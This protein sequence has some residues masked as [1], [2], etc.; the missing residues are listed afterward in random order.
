MRKDF[1]CSTGGWTRDLVLA[2]QVL[3]H[4]SHSKSPSPPFIHAGN[5]TSGFCVLA[6][7]V[8]KVACHLYWLRGV[9]GNADRKWKLKEKKSRCR[10]LTY[11]VLAT[12]EGEIR[13]IEVWDQPWQILC[14]TPHHQKINA[15]K[16]IRGMSQ[17]IEHK[18]C[19]CKALSS[20]PSPIKKKKSGAQWRCLGN[21]GPTLPR[22]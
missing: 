14:G 3:Y 9:N 19:K 11:V 22:N 5:Q 18:L 15:A 16:W 17:T 6:V 2:R 21:R 10:W 1:F 7:K 13:R 4:W 20:N 12:W 8:Y